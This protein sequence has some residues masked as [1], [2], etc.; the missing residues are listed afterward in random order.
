VGST[1]P[2][3]DT[4]A[5]YD[6][7]SDQT[8]TELGFCRYGNQWALC[9]REVDYRMQSSRFGGC[10]WQAVRTSAPRLLVKAPRTERIKA[11]S[12]LPTLLRALKEAAEESLQTIQDAKTFVEEC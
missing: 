7:A 10:E 9:L 12:G 11:L 5:D 1:F 4:V 2:D 3:A 8:D 6:E